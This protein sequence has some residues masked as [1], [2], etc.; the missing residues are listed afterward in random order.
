MGLRAVC[1]VWYSKDMNLSDF[2]GNWVDLLIVIFLLVYAWEGFERG[3]LVL[4][5]EMVSFVISLVVALR[6]YPEAAKLLA[7]SF[8][9]PPEISKAVG[10][11]LTAVGAEVVFGL[12]LGEVYRRLPAGW[13]TKR[14]NQVLGFLPALADGLMLV[15][16]VLTALVGLPVSGKVKSDILG[17]RIGGEIVRRMQGVEAKVDDIFGGA[18][19]ETLSFL[20]VETGSRET[21]DLHFSTTRVSVDAP[22]EE[23]MFNLVNKERVSRGLSPLEMDERLREVARAH[24][25]DMFARGYFSHITPEGDDPF[26]RMRAAGISFVSAGENI[27][28]APS[29][30]IAHGGLMNSPGHRANILDSDFHRVGIGVVD[31]GVYGK[32]FTQDFT[33]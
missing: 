6:F 8:L 30:E 33:D 29:V 7:E 10:F 13:F 12:I 14:W 2:Q 23:E 28:Y 17:S 19:R 32:M 21:I 9:W 26:Q 4:L 1:R 16:V 3:F 25:E 31:G 15:A 24:S 18:I 27:A 5:G 11:V 22:A 20:T